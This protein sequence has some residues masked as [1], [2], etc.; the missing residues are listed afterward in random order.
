V[1]R[2]V[3][4]AE[5]RVHVEPVRVAG[6]RPIRSS[7]KEATVISVDMQLRICLDQKSPCRP[8]GAGQRTGVLNYGIGQK[9]WRDPRG[10]LR[11]QDK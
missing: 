4:A 11:C 2:E 10:G 8:R 5:R 7:T 1:R 3:G 9:P 6:R